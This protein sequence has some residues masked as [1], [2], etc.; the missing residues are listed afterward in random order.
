MAADIPTDTSV[1][2]R[3]FLPTAIISMVRAVA[4]LIPLIQ[5][6]D[7]MLTDLAV[8]YVVAIYDTVVLQIHLNISR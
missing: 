3:P 4:M 2:C 7:G 1:A 6:A 5:I 8:D